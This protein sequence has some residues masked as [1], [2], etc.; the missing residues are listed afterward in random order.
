MLSSLPPPPPENDE[1]LEQVPVQGIQFWSVWSLEV[2]IDPQ[3]TIEGLVVCRGP[4]ASPVPPPH[5]WNFGMPGP[6]E[7][8][9]ILGKNPHSSSTTS[10]FT[11]AGQDLGGASITQLLQQGIQS[12]TNPSVSGTAAIDPQWMTGAPEPGQRFG[13]GFKTFRRSSIAPPSLHPEGQV[14]FTIAT[15]SGEPQLPVWHS[16]D[17]SLQSIT[18]AREGN[19]PAQSHVQNGIQVELEEADPASV[20]SQSWYHLP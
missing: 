16:S 20:F 1:G 12:V 2:S 17:A 4:G 8:L 15:P 9:W 13:P 18:W 6:G 19:Q 7:E 5:G 11:L 10:A 3:T 14:A